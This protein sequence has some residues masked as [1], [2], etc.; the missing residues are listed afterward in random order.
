M[1]WCEVVRR[2]Q[3]DRTG[4]PSLLA[5]SLGEGNAASAAAR[6]G[7]HDNKVG[8]HGN[9][10]IDCMN[11][12]EKV[13]LRRRIRRGRGL[14]RVLSR[15]TRA[16]LKGNGDLIK[17]LHLCVQVHATFPNTVSACWCALI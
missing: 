9:K 4:S 14:A 11:G 16:S 6:L 13:G 10:V 2:S 7:A 17:Q 15:V 5:R 12:G 3:V 1:K 8:A